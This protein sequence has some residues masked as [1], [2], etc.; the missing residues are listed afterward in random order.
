MTLSVSVSYQNTHTAVVSG[1]H[2]L[3]LLQ[4]GAPFFPPP[5]PAPLT[6][7]IPGSLAGSSSTVSCCSTVEAVTPPSHPWSGRV[8]VPPKTASHPLQPLHPIIITAEGDGASSG[9]LG[10]VYVGLPPRRGCHP[11]IHLLGP[12]TAPPIVSPPPLNPGPGLPA[13]NSQS[14]TRRFL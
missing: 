11:L 12:G 13:C 4:K 1:L 9:A 3:V 8:L 6:V 5:S 7:R 2:F 10:Q 14:G